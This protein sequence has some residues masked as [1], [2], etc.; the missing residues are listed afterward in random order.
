MQSVKAGS[1][2]RTGRRK[3]LK[4]G[5]AAGVATVSAGLL[6]N[7][8]PAFAERR[9]DG[10][11]ITRG[12]I[13]ILQFLAAAEILETDLWQQYN[14]LGGVNAANSGYVAALSVLDSDMPQY[15]SDNTDDEISHEHFSQRVSGLEG[16]ANG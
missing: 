1:E 4:N 15:I 8:S 6:A 2:H 10:P 7:Q 14:E 13:A 9:D 12:D 11:D 5:V 16:R 3:F